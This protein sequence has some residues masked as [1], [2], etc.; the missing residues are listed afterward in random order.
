M[1]LRFKLLILFVILAIIP[2]GFASRNMI[3]IT[4]DELKSAAN[5]ELIS[6]AR[7]VAQEIED[8]YTYTWVAPLKLMKE[9]IESESLG[10]NEIRSLLVEGMKHIYDFAALQIS[11]KG[12]S[13]PFLAMQVDYTER[14]RKAD[15]DPNKVLG[16]PTDV[17]NYDNPQEVQVS[18]PQYLSEI[19][20]W[21]LTIYFPLDDETFG[22]PAI[23][24][25][26]IDLTS[27]I[28]RIREYQ[29]VGNRKI[30]V[31]DDAGKQL[32]NRERTDLTDKEIVE[33]A[34]GMI[35]SDSKT[36]AVSPYTDSQDRLYLGA[37][38]FPNSLLWGV[39]VEKAEAD[40]YAA[41]DQMIRNLVIWVV[42]GLVIAVLGAVIFSISLTKPLMKLTKAASRI[43]KGDLKTSV[44][45][46]SRRDEIGM[47]SMA[48]GK[49]VT[50]LNHYIDELTRTTAKKERAESELRL[51]HD[52]QQS[53]LPKSFPDLKEIDVWG[54]CDP[55][56]EVG[57]DYFD[58]FQ[59]DDEH[60]A[61]VI[62][63]VSG[64]GVGAS[65]YMAMSRT[66][67]R[68]IANS[69]RSPGEVVTEFNDSLV[70]LSE[71]SNLFI[72]FFYALYNVKTKKMIWSTAG[73]NMPYVKTNGKFEML[74]QDST[75]VAGM[76]DGFDMPEREMT[77]KPGDILFL[78]TDGL[79]EPIDVDEEEFG[80]ERLEEL[81]N[82]Y[83]EMSPEEF[84]KK[85]VEEVKKFQE[86][87]PQFDDMTVL[88]MKVLA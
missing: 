83:Y 30:F 8:S 23:F 72:T 20:S 33:K 77:L 5:F 21:I 68:M 9:S 13:Q 61:L 2:L 32:F 34:V 87:M 1:S 45:G 18:Q 29:S 10:I 49:M 62:G 56:R 54:M 88:T 84:S 81:M 57:G 28:N 15:V 74:P 63:D 19:D 52:I 67:F 43:A 4:E 46:E 44:E 85:L 64:K 55:A 79:T 6:A 40:A 12:V 11:V 82:N 69:P 59:I 53:F 3:K 58:F 65:L 71:Y 48:F 42:I 80:E 35:N 31:F 25:A 76:M 78:Y 70:A 47:L 27:L 75:L 51:A 17:L 86:G 24:S 41:V 73:H 36:S 39:V 37:Y 50:D 16:I 7:E 38:S 14:L 66:L 60:Y 22:R 26:R